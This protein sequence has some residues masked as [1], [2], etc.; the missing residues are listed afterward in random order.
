[1]L[2]G[3][4]VAS[5][6]THTHAFG[7]GMMPQTEA[8]KRVIER[9]GKYAKTSTLKLCVDYYKT[10]SAQDRQEIMKELDLR[11]QLSVKDHKLI[12][13][14]TVEPGMTMC[15]MYMSVGT[16]KA[17]KTRQLRPMVFK[18]VHVYPEMYY[19]TQSGMV[20]EM[21]QRKEGEMPPKLIH[22]KPKVQPSPTL[23]P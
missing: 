6:A 16:P 14:H 21:Y 15:G 22:E 10:E 7:A 2:A 5:T 18:T 9:D 13:K 20:V 19:V 12:S 11:G 3:L 4:V 8:G 23:K 1:M 17:Q